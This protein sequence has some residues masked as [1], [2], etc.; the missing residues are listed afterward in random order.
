MGSLDRM[1]ASWSSCQDPAALCSRDDDGDDVVNVH[2][3]DGDDDDRDKN[4]ENG[5]EICVLTQNLCFVVNWRSGETEVGWFAVI[6]N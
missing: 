4:D 2:V 3:G 1:S 6:W 5:D